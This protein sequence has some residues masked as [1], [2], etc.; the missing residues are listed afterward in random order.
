MRTLTVLVSTL[1]LAA[2][3]PGQP[4]RNQRAATKGAAVPRPVLDAY[5]ALEFKGM[6]YRLLLPAGYD[7]GKQYPLI[8]SLHGRAGV[9]SDNVSQMRRWTATFVDPAWRA[10][11]LCIVLAPQAMDSWVIDG[12]PAPVMTDELL[13]GL[14]D[15]WRK[16]LQERPTELKPVV[17]GAL[18][19]AFALLDTICAEYAVDRNRIYVLG[20]SMGGFGSWNAI[21]AAPQRFAAAIPSAGGLPPWQDYAKFKDVPTWTFHGSADPTVPVEYTREIFARIRKLG[22]NLKYTELE[23][24]NHNAETHAFAYQGDDA[25]K[26]FVTRYSSDQCDRTPNVWDWLFKQRLDSR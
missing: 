4:A 16:R 25:A 24:V 21:W 19:K 6:P 26:G 18:T 12:Q 9:G 5:Q 2:T 17:D 10:K 23:G 8:L 22:G 1:L 3:A 14:S 20:H 13:A 7:A 15:A 11:Y